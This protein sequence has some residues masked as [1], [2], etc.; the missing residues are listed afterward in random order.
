MQ[1]HEMKLRP[2]PFAAVASGKK[3]IE[4]RLFD[5]KRRTI[6][7]GDHIRFT[8]PKTGEAVTAAVLTLHRFPDFA[9]LYEALL[10]RVGPEGLGYAVGEAVS[11]AD[12]LDYYTAEDITRWGV[13]GIELGLLPHAIYTDPKNCQ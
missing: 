10:P 6:A 3:R 1:T 7:V 8:C 9:A 12:M 13:V 11:P 4:L 5:E 2:R